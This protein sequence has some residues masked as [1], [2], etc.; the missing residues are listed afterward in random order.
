MLWNGSPQKKRIQSPGCFHDRHPV[1]PQLILFHDLFFQYGKSNSINRS[2][3][4]SLATGE[5]TTSS[6]Y[7]IY[8]GTVAK[9]HPGGKAM[10]GADNG[11]SP[12]DIEKY[13][14]QSG[15]ASVLY[16]SPY[17]GDYAMCGDL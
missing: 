11:I 12:S 8:A 3:C 14:I 6:G 1:Y 7:S 13:D 4:I 9:L 16:D 2:P 10:Y 17:H 15:T 5:E